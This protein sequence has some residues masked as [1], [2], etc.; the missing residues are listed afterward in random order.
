MSGIKSRI[1]YPI[2]Y[3]YRG[4]RS[5]FLSSDK[6][7]DLFYGDN[8][9]VTDGDL[10]LKFDTSSTASKRWFYPRYKDGSM[11]EPVVSRTLAD[12]LTTNST[13]FDVGAHV[14]FYSVLGSTICSEVHAFEMDP[15][16][17]STVAAHFDGRQQEPAD[18]HIV[19]APVS[20]TSGDF[21]MFTPHQADNLSTN[22]ITTDQ[23]FQQKPSRFQLQTVALD[24]YVEQTEV[25]PD[26]LK[27]D[28]E[29]FELSVLRGLSKTIDDVR[30]LLIELHPDLLNR[31]DSDANEVLNLLDEYGFTNQRFTDHRA[32]TKPEKSLELIDS[33]TPIRKNGMILCTR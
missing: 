5:N 27:I 18:V 30:A 21:V 20:D 31:Y 12:L 25:Q 11:H 15:R 8:L 32:T 23:F 19:P 6:V 17:A 28:V 29:G 26:V 16:L 4:I 9:T 22:S 7:F 13:F 2:K 10:T 24:E 1:P 14:G 3:L 33:D